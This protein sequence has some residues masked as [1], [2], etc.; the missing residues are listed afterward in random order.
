MQPDCKASR[1]AAPRPAVGPA[2]RP[3]APGA[4]QQ[5][6]F[7]TGLRGPGPR[8]PSPGAAARPGAEQGRGRDRGARAAAART[9]RSAVPPPTP[10]LRSELHG[11]AAARPP[12]APAPHH[13]ARSGA[14]D[15][16]SGPAATAATP[17]PGWGPGRSRRGSQ[18]WLH[19]PGPAHRA[20]SLGLA[21]ASS[22][23]ETAGARSVGA[24][25]R[26]IAEEVAFTLRPPP[27][28][29]MGIWRRSLT[30]WKGR[31]TLTR[32][33]RRFCIASAYYVPPTAVHSNFHP[34][35]NLT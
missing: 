12:G 1:G 13:T 27:G 14:N 7:A 35:P 19:Q 18:G 6:H 16:A 34:N 2:A 20:A 3:S 21:S 26:G 17:P 31:A 29:W 25:G 8:L 15:A 33:Y 30:E 4:M 24:E 28:L 11:P 23:R 5:L 32:V 9:H 22:N 10:G